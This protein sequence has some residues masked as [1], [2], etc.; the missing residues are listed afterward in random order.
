M[1]EEILD[2]EAIKKDFWKDEND[3]DL[4][5]R[6]EAEFLVEG[7]IPLEVISG[8]VVYN[9]VAQKRLLELGI[10]NDKIVT[11]ENFYF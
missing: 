5:R 1:L 4:K 8:W 6:K 2:F 11:R 10:P 7:D 9:E 3:L